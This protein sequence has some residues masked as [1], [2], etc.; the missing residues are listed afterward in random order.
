MAIRI[1]DGENLLKPH[2][3][4]FYQVLANE[5]GIAHWKI[6][7]VYG[8]LQLSV[9]WAILSVRP[10]GIYAVLS[11]LIILFIGFICANYVV[12]RRIEKRTCHKLE[13]GKKV[14]N[15]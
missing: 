1:N 9:G 12:R 11:I 7:L 10:L 2:R 3:R 8:V 14:N 4:H 5:S 13:A 15:S 6:S